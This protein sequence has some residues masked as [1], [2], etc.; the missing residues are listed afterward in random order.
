MESGEV[1]IKVTK[2]DFQY[3]WKKVRE[4]T[5]SL[6]SGLHFGHYIA[7]AFSNRLSEIHAL[8]LLVIA[9]TGYAPD[10]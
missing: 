2:E 4:R 5:A 3:Y 10:R 6:Y 9:K 7:A 1:D 8:K